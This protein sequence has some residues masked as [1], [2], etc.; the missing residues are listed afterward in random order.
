MSVFAA[1]NNVVGEY[2]EG[3][4]L[5]LNIVQGRLN[6]WTEDSTPILLNLKPQ[7]ISSQNI[8]PTLLIHCISF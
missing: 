3:I 8:I 2:F 6:I 1:V 5:M 4:E 7:E